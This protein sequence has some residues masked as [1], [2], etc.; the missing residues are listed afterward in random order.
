MGVGLNGE[1]ASRAGELR[2]QRN[3]N[4]KR[5]ALISFLTLSLISEG[6]SDVKTLKKWNFFKHFQIS[7]IKVV[8]L[9]THGF[10]A[11]FSSRNSNNKHSIH[12][13]TSQLLL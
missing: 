3:T 8:H 10:Y 7:L 4:G 11:T 2:P 1:A 13:P 6:E 12:L 9:C 5:P